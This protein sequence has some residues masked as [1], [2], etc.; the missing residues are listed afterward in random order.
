M[1]TLLQESI[2]LLQER[3]KVMQAFDTELEK[4]EK[5]ILGCYIEEN[6]IESNVIYEFIFS[7][8]ERHISYELN[9]LN[10]EESY[11]E[12]YDIMNEW[13]P[14]YSPID[15]K[16]MKTALKWLQRGKK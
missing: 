2:N 14:V 15:S 16:K 10:P 7:M 11:F 12:K 3:I 8:E 1:P 6:E 4:I 9:L 13:D 5:E